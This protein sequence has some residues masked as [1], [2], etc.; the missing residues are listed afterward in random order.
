M[1]DTIQSQILE[2]ILRL[3]ALHD[4]TLSVE[5]EKQAHA[6]LEAAKEWCESP[7]MA[8]AEFMMDLTDPDDVG[9]FS[10]YREAV[11]WIEYAIVLSYYRVARTGQF[12]AKVDKYL[13][14]QQG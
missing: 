4:P 10:P 9:T 8:M 7:R 14:N 2:R 3:E 6:V 11:S 1:S 5:P 13:V 12:L